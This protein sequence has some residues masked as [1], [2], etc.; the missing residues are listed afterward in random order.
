MNL[1]RNQP[2]VSVVIPVY[3]RADTIKRAVDSVLCQTYKNIELIVVDDGSED[4]TVNIL[5]QMDKEKVQI[6]TQNH[7]GANAARN[8]GIKRSKGELVAFQDSDDEWLP[9]KLESQIAYMAAN[10]YKACYCP[11]FSYTDGK[12]A[13]IFPA[14]YKDQQKYEE[15]LPDLLRTYNVVS[16]QTLVIHRD[17]ILDVG[18]FDEEMPR[19]QDYEYVIRIIQK[20]RMGYINTPLVKV[21]RS[22][23]SISKD[24]VKLKEAGLK[25]LKKHGA[26]FDIQSYFWNVFGK[27]IGELSESEVNRKIEEMDNYLSA[28]LH[29]ADINIYKIA[30]EYLN[31]AYMSSKEFSREE[32][33][34]R[35]G[36]LQSGKFAIY[37]AGVIGKKICCDLQKKGLKP[38]CFLVT[39]KKHADELCGIPVVGLGGLEERGLEIII[40]VSQNL[41]LELAR[42]LIDRGCTNYFR[43]PY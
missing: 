2:L 34:M 42:N 35:I 26:F 37:G 1:G 9:D 38:R 31:H 20:R 28:Y 4:G 3:N 17:I 33:E 14:D 19:L 32:Y 18:F 36:K 39:E 5:E 41:Q 7:R 43:C 11:F 13:E 23:D 22:D 10:D 6:V 16:T 25:L 24:E 40:A 8:L 12:H 29:N 27:S 30:A 15:H 21:Y